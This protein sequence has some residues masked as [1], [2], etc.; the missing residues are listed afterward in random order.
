MALPIGRNNIDGAEVRRTFRMGDRVLRNGDILTSE[1]VRSIRPMNLTS[2]I[3]RGHIY[4]WPKGG[5]ADASTTVRYPVAKGFGK[6]DVYEGRK[7]N[8]EPLTRE[9]AYNL[10]GVPMPENGGGKDH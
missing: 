2:L 7:L 4:V 3:E 9:E 5:R 10:A 8:D 6:Y 1:E